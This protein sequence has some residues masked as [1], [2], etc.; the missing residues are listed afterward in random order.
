MYT[1]NDNFF[2]CIKKRQISILLFIGVLFCLIGCGREITAPVYDDEPEPVDEVSMFVIVS[3]ID[4]VNSKITVRAVGFDDEKTLSYTG[5]ADVLDQYGDLLTMNR[6]P[7]G[8]LADVIYDSNRDKLLSLKLSSA[9]SVMK[10]EGVSGVIVDNVEKTMR[11]NGTTYPMSKNI[12]AFSD[13]NE[14]DVDEICSEDQIS[15]WIYNDMVCSAYVELGHGYVKL[16]DYASYLGGMV[17]IGYDVIVP[18]TE[19]MLLT[20]REGEYTLRIAKDDDVGTKK[21]EIIKNQEIELSL[22]DLVIEPKQMGS[23]LFKLTPGDAAVYIDG[24]KVNT[25]GAVKLAYGKHKIYI[26]ADGYDTYSASFNVNYA[27]KIKEYVLKETGSESESS[28]KQD[29]TSSNTAGTTEGQND[30]TGGTTEKEN[31]STDQE[32]TGNKVTVASPMGASVYL[33]GEYLG[34]API[35]FTKVTGSHIITFSMA[36]FLSKSYTV[37]FT[38]DGKDTTLNYDDLVSIASLIE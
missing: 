19:N 10:L 4:D 14:I 27:Y 6:V 32:K 13:N 22:A 23:I 24:K 31:H 26:T 35:S 5:S 7:L 28:Q 16:K 36:G 25:E 33:D 3:N 12:S 38:N 9:D 15:V 34:V 2:Y 11:I 20:V 30:K 1:G 37:N 18:V 17:E 21:V 29:N 8:C